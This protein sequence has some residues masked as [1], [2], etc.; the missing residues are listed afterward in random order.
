MLVLATSYCCCLAYNIT[1]RP[2]QTFS[3]TGRA[4]HC[5]DTDEPSLIRVAK[6]N[7]GHTGPAQTRNSNEFQIVGCYF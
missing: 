1:P 5:S 6:I 4:F 7:L 3:G 2:L